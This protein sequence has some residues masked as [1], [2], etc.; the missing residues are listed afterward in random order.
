MTT[1]ASKSEQV[2]RGPGT[3]NT[4]S[5]QPLDIPDRPAGAVDRDANPPISDPADDT[6]DGGVGTIPSRSPKLSYRRT[7][8]AKPAPKTLITLTIRAQAERA[9]QRRTRSIGLRSLR[10]RQAGRRRRRLTNNQP[11]RARKPAVMMKG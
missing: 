3:H 2:D 7:K 1:G 6:G 8:A 9:G 4:G 5:D 10:T 11:R